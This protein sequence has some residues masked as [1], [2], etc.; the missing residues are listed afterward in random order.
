MAYKEEEYGV[1]KRVLY[2][3]Y[4]G[5]I[6]GDNGQTYF[7]HSDE[8]SG[9]PKGFDTIRVGDKVKFFTEPHEWVHHTTQ[10]T[11]TGFRAV[12]VRQA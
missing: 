9:G 7:F 4:Y 6:D 1:V 8:V 2:G 11:M 3:K 12:R 10:K 5:F